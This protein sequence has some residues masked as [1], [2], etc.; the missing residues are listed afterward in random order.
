M[1]AASMNATIRVLAVVP[2][3]V[4]LFGLVGCSGEAVSAPAAGTQAQQDA[5]GTAEQEGENEEEP[6]L[7]GLVKEKAEQAALAAYPGTV[8]KSEHDAEKP[9]LYAVEIKKIDGGVV[10]VYLD[11]GYQVVDTKQEDTEEDED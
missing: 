5:G 2:L 4:L 9:G 11:T 6:P 3:A 1:E 8:L 7:T 10:E